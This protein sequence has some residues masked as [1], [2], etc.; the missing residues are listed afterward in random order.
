MNEKGGRYRPGS[1]L[2][3]AKRPLSFVRLPVEQGT[4]YADMVRVARKSRAAVAF[5]VWTFLLELAADNKSGLRGWIIEEDKPNGSWKPASME[6]LMRRSG[7]SRRHLEIGIEVL[8]DPEVYWITH[9]AFDGLGAP[10][11]AAELHGAPGDSAHPSE[12]EGER[13]LEVQGEVQGEGK[14][15]K[16]RPPVNENHRTPQQHHEALRLRFAERVC[17]R[18]HLD[19]SATTLLC[20]TLDSMDLGALAEERMGRFIKDAIARDNP[21]SYAMKVLPEIAKEHPREKGGT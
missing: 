9:H 4:G 12:G 7:F 2:E 16:P 20:A 14:P 5:G 17:K 21:S 15:E 6:F 11:N 3:T 18:V 10:R 8:R 13:E 1:G 19:K